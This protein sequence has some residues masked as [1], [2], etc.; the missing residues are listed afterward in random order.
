[1]LTL[2]LLGRLEVLRDGAAVE[3]P[4]SKKTR[5]LLAYLAV[6]GRPQRRERLCELLW[7]I[8]DDPR[9][10][11]RWSLS[12]LRAVVDDGGEGRILADRET[13][14]F[15]PAG[16]EIDLRAVAGRLGRDPGKVATADLAALAGRFRGDFL[17]GTDFPELHDF[18]AWLV[19]EREEARALHARILD[20]LC[21]RL[22]GDPEAALPHARTRV[23]IDPYNAAARAELCRLL[24]A[25]GR[26]EEAARQAETARLLLG[27]EA[28]PAAPA[29]AAAEPHQEIRFCTAA[30]GVRLAYATV[31]GGP[32]LVKAGNWLNHLEFDWR[33][34]V[35]RHIIRNLSR[36]F[37]LVRYD[38]RGNGLSDW[39]VDDLS[40]E[41][42]VRDLETVV[43]GLGLDRFA[44][45]GISQGSSVSIAYAARHP[46]RVSH[47]IIQGG[48][49]Q[50]WAIRGNDADHEIRKA[51]ITLIEKGW[52][53]ENPAFR[54]A[55]TSLFIPGGSE[56]HMQ[57]FNELQ[58]ITTS[59]AGAAR[60]QQAMAGIDV[61]DLAP[62]V[63]APTL[64]LHARGDAAVPFDQ[65]RRVASLI[66]G[67]RFVPLEG[68]NHLIL[69]HEPA[70]PIYIA[71]LRKFLGVA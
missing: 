58:R 18:Q 30:D 50:G 46:D 60:L 40:L 45:L 36:D 69:E 37:Q 32:P 61:S 44:L 48:Y 51:M 2:N 38:A 7:N 12:K 25:A 66:P 67:A 63:R 6:T 10:A 11:L 71:E 57:W 55:F 8:P 29:A 1:M 68:N 33:S 13:V 34:P 23:E 19:A 15:D 26:H 41:V 56:Q 16:V 31:G 9:G 4:P 62:L 27:E 24:A 42:S 49:V 14:A 22:A 5:A 53:A 20:E 17:E 52:G 21:R 35:W 43:D 3:L 54:Q 65:G 47:L 59:P 28:V 64:V 70:W 39:D